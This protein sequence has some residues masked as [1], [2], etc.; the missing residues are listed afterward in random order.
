MLKDDCLLADDCCSFSA[1]LAMEETAYCAAFNGLSVLG[2][3][4]FF[5][6][7]NSPSF[8]SSKAPARTSDD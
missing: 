5:L 2:A 7:N 8:K 6:M 3:A 1:L 4:F